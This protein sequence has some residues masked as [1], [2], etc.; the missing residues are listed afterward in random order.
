M[1][2]SND[3]S[4]PF[5]QT[6][7]VYQILVFH[8]CLQL[9][10]H[11][12]FIY[13]FALHI[14][15]ITAPSFLDMNGRG[16]LQC[17]SLLLRPHNVSQH[18]AHLEQALSQTS[19][20]SNSDFTIFWLYDVVSL[21]GLCF[22]PCKLWMRYQ[23]PKAV[24]IIR[25]GSTHCIPSMLSGTDCRECALE[26]MKSFLLHSLTQGICLFHRK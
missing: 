21:N 23:P 6:S 15:Q 11:L 12:I 3:I 5:Q 4:Q 8:T 19:L 25:R 14:L 10:L 20:R 2:L 24:V 26:N 13:L 9:P 18:L 22:T 16:A 7:C 17:N 1:T